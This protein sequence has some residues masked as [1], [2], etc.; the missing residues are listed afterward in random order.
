MS[1]VSALSNFLKILFLLLLILVIILA[2][3]YWFDHLGVIDYRRLIGPVEEHL[4]AFLRRGERVGESPLLLE[5][6]FVEKQAQILDAR[7][8]ELEE[9]GRELDARARELQ[10]LEARLQEEAQRLQEEEKVLSQKQTA[11]DNYTDNVRK[12]AEYLISMQPEDAV[13]RLSRL[14][15]LLIIDI[16]REVDR[17]AEE[18][19]GLSMVPVYLS[20]MEP[21]KAAAVQR[22]MTK[23]SS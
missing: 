18:T 8:Q 12:Q 2:G 11:Y 17:I 21:E 10:E 5:K 16:L 1:A 15:D 19:G 7:Q 4:P 9:R 22:K 20:L 3:I 14:N 13:E 6:E 23:V